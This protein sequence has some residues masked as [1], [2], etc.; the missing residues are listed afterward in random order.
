MNGKPGTPGKEMK[1]FGSNSLRLMRMFKALRNPVMFQILET[2]AQRRSCLT[3]EI[4]ETTPLVELITV[5]QM[6]IES[7]D[8]FR[9]QRIIERSFHLRYQQKVGSSE[10]PLI[11]RTLTALGS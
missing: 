8:F 4:I 10:S 3:N 2:L 7:I 11:N 9:V 6:S 5:G 1:S